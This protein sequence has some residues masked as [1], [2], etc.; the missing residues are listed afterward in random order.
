MKKFLT[1]S[2]MA[3]LLA[4]LFAACAPA[5][6][7]SKPAVDPTVS[8]TNPVADSISVATSTQIT[9]TFDT[10]WTEPQ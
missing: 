6:G 8:S 3:V 10:R 5:G 2:L 7:S 9:A 4:G 1:A